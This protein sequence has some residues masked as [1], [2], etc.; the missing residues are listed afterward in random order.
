MSFV[1]HLESTADGTR[2]PAGTMQ[3]THGNR[4]LL[5]K[6]DIEAVGKAVDP[7]VI[8]TRTPSL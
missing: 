3:T 5:V 6:Y 7:A 4:P 2:F 1:S 8:R